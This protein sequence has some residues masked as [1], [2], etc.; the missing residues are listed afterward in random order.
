ML[1][2]CERDNRL[3]SSSCLE[4]HEKNQVEVQ[5]VCNLK[6]AQWD[7]VVS[8]QERFEEHMCVFDLE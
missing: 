8:H 1:D 4:L 2:E 7:K 5:V 3:L 6:Q